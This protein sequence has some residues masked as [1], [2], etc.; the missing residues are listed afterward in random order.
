MVIR[1]LD[2]L[3]RPETRCE[4]QCSN[5]LSIYLYK[6]EVS[7]GGEGGAVTAP[8]RKCLF[9]LAFWTLMMLLTLVGSLAIVPPSATV[10]H[11]L[12][13]VSFNAHTCL[14]YL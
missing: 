10:R 4:R 12:S 7:D 8:L 6:R 11:T 13:C 14:K 9:G 2:V 1:L 5:F 3:T